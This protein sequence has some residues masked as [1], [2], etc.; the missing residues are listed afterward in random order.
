MFNFCIVTSLHVRAADFYA[1]SQQ[2]IMLVRESSTLFSVPMVAFQPCK[3]KS[4]Y[5]KS[6][7]DASM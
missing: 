5:Q 3:E 7:C 6:R 1:Q 2:Y 4:G